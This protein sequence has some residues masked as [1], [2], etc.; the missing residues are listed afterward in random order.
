MKFCCLLVWFITEIVTD[1]SKSASV[2]VGSLKNTKTGKH[3]PQITTV[4]KMVLKQ[5]IN[6]IQREV[7]SFFM[8]RSATLVRPI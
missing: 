1:N 8:R 2:C 4:E 5:C 6:S 7:F 3:S